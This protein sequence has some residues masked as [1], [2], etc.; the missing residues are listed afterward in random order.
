MTPSQQTSHASP[1]P[2][3]IAELFSSIGVSPMDWVDDW[4]DVLAMVTMILPSDP[5]KPPV[6]TNADP[7]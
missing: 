4:V 6:R 2:A 5:D 1:C 3:D 7:I